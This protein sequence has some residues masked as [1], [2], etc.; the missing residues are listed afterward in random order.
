M[1]GAADGH[2][3]TH[4]LHLQTQLA[5]GPLEFI[6][7]PTRN[8]HH[9]IIE[10][11]LKHGTCG[12]CDRV[13]QFVKVVSDGKLCSDLGNRV[14]GGLGCQRRRTAHTRIYLDGNDVFLLVVR[15]GE[16]YVATT[17]KVSDFAHHANRHV[18]HALERGVTEGHGRSDRN[19]VPRV[20]AHRVKVL[21]RTDD[22]HVVVAVAQQLQFV[23][24]PAHDRLVDHDLVDGT[25]V[26]PAGQCLVE[27]SGVVNDARTGSSQRIARSNAQRETELLSSLLAFEETFGCGLR[28]HGNAHGFHQ[29]TESLAVFGDLNGINIHPDHAHIVLFPNAHF[30]ALD[31]QVQGGL[32]AHSRQHRVDVGVLFKDLLDGSWLKR[33]QVNVIRHHRIGH[34]GRGIGVDEGG[35]DSFFSKGTERLG[36]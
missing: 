24:L 35:F 30:I 23:F 6:E 28:R 27:I 15:H 34:D 7:V 36:T 10:C 16:L 20:D 26:Q 2:D 21:D 22:G 17:R 5:V 25:Q 8:L 14:T 29:I 33:L 11:R 3:L 32:T 4:C 31:A 1:E 13:G 9:H 19:A 12:A 18:P